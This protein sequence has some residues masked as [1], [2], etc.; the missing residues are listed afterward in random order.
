MPRTYQIEILGVIYTYKGATRSQLK[1]ALKLTEQVEMEDYL[2]SVCVI[3]PKIDLENCLAGIPV[4]LTELILTASGMDEV[5]TK[6]FQDESEEW[7]KSPSGKLEILMMAV[8]HKTQEEI[9]NLDP[10][11]WFKAASAAQLI[12]ATMYGLPVEE[13]MNLDPF[14]KKPKKGKQNISLARAATT[15][16]QQFTVISKDAKNIPPALINPHR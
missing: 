14:D 15:E 16:N 1:I 2:C 6:S 12:A 5:G 8:L 7:I 13:F 10:P 3:N 4:R 11:D 9:D